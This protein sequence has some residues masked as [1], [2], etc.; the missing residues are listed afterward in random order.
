MNKRYFSIFPNTKD[1]VTVST[2][3][4]ELPKI[5]PKIIQIPDAPEIEEFEELEFIS[6]TVEQIKE[7]SDDELKSVLSGAYQPEKILPMSLQSLIVLELSDGST[8]ILNKSRWSHRIK[9]YDF[10]F[11]LT[12]ILLAAI[13]AWIAYNQS[14]TSQNKQS[15]SQ[16]IEY[17]DYQKSQKSQEKPEQDLETIQSQQTQQQKSSDDVSHEREL[18]DSLNTHESEMPQQEPEKQE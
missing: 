9:T 12:S 11:G 10:W 4:P 2:P 3:A 1:V 18:P 7:M 8:K 6:L 13:S 14:Q 16:V 5:E 15:A 17:V